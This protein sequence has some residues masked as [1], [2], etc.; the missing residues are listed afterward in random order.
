MMET[1]KAAT[2]APPSD[3]GMLSMAQAHW[4][5]DKD[6]IIASQARGGTIIK[7]EEDSSTNARVALQMGPPPLGNAAFK[8]VNI[9]EVDNICNA[10]LS[11]KKLLEARDI[12]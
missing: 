12:P 1:L 3:D 7:D 9:V 6:S 4:Q 5:Y 11:L 8:Y 2:A 10:G